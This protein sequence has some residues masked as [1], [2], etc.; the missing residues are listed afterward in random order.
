M[1]KNIFLRRFLVC[2]FPVLL[3]SSNVVAV[4][5]LEEQCI[6]VKDHI[7]NNKYTYG[8]SL[9]IAAG[10][11]LYFANQAS[12]AEIGAESDTWVEMDASCPAVLEAQWQAD[13]GQPFLNYLYFREGC[14]VWYGVVEGCVRDVCEVGEQMATTLINM[15][16]NQY[17]T[18]ER[19]LVLKAQDGDMCEYEYV[20][21]NNE[22]YSRLG[23]FFLQ[24]AKRC[25]R[26]P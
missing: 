25:L 5:W 15:G 23:H 18:V 2:L 24:A 8:S 22:Q 20:Q 10:G 26:R 14:E 1:N 19:V 9:I 4:H 7:I 6:A 16:R 3:L 13:R 21:N 17:Q 11:V 12:G